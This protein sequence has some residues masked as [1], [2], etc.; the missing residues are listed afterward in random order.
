M[1][2][3]FLDSIRSRRSIYMIG[4]QP[5]IS[6]ERIAELIRQALQYTPSS[7]NMQS[8]RAVLLLH[9]QHDELWSIVLETLRKVTE[10]EK[11]GATQQKI[12]SFAAGYGT[13]LFFDDTSVVGKFANK[14]PLYRDNFPVWAQQSNGMFQFSVWNLLEAEG[15]G[16]NLQHYNPLIDEQVKERWDIPDVWQLIAQ[17]PFGNPTGEAGEKTFQDIDQR[18]KMYR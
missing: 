9:E 2:K 7:F 1:S 6:D 12:G 11:F 15:L 8:A 10:P 13:V 4:K 18:F 16:A 17:M 14:F 5:G 3:D